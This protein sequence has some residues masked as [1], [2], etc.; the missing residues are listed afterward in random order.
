MYGAPTEL[1][2]A[3]MIYALVARII[4]RIPTI[5][6]I[7]LFQH[8]LE[9][10]FEFEEREW[11]DIVLKHLQSTFRKSIGFTDGKMKEYMPAGELLGSVTCL[12]RGCFEDGVLDPDSIF[13]VHPNLLFGILL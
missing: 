7:D 10:R 1:D 9:E 6:K 11:T 3:A 8:T 13:L 4:E 12:F 5:K 2:Y